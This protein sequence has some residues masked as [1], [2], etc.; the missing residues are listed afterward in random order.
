M[1]RRKALI[2]GVRLLV[3]ADLRALGV[4]VPGAARRLPR[5]APAG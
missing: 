5:A 1:N 3:E 4:E 2:T